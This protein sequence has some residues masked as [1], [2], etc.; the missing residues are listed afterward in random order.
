M[1]TFAFTSFRSSIQI[2]IPSLSDSSLRSVMPSILFSFTSSAIF[3]INLALLTIYGSSV[4][5]ILLLPFAIVSIFVTLRTFILP[6]PVRYASSVPRVP[7]IIPPVGKSGPLIIGKSSSI[8]VSLSSLTRLS[9]I[10]TTA[11]ITSF[12]LCGGI[13]VAIPTAIPCVPFTSK[14]G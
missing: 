14:L 13:F 5:I 10:L 3:S 4:T 8:S 11:A 2:R 1:M 9:I 7:R 12:K 6:R